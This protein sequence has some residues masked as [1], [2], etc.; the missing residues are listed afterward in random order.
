MCVAAG[1]E[2]SHLVRPEVER[3]TPGNLRATNHHEGTS[4]R[5]G[6]FDQAKGRAKEAVGDLTDDDKMKS[7]GKADRAS[8]KVKEKVD[9]AKDWVEDKVDDVRNKVD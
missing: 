2:G 5:S 9:D 1:W 4:T 8:G 6:K 3:S 7:E